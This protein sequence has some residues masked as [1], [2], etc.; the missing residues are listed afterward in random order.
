MNLWPI[1]HFYNFWAWLLLYSAIAPKSEDKCVQKSFIF[2]K[3]HSF[4]IGTLVWI[5]ARNHGPF[6]DQLFITKIL[7]CF[8]YILRF[9]I[10]LVIRMIGHFNRF[11]GTLSFEH[12]KNGSFILFQFEGSKLNVS[13]NLPLSWPT[14]NQSYRDQVLQTLTLYCGT[15]IGLCV[16]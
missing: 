8:A 10:D 16:Q 15:H 12:F 2:P 5:S 1:E 7:Y 13:L 6:S 4:K 11:S 9:E 3:W 14:S